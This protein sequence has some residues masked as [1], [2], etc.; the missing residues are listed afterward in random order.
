MARFSGAKPS[1]E[2]IIAKN[3]AR[4]NAVLATY[5]CVFLAIGLLV[6]VVRI[7]ANS[8]GGGLLS[9]ITFQTFPLV[10]VIMFGVA[11]ALIAVMLGNFKKIMLSGSEY[12]KIDPNKVLSRKEREIYGLLEDLVSASKTPFTPELYIMDAPYMN[13]F[14]SGWDEKNS[15]IALTSALV[16]NLEPDEL[17]AVIAHELS[18]IRHGDVRLT[19]AVGI[20]GNVMLL[21]ANYAIY[22]FG[23]NQKNSGANLARVILL[24]L[25]VVLPFLTMFLQMYL[26]RSREYMADSGAAFIMGDSKPMIRALQK[27]SEGYK[28]S[29]FSGVDVNPTRRAAYLFDFKE[30]FSTHP[31]IEN[32]IKSLL[33]NG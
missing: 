22:L 24:V 20:L 11:I 5:L 32:R 19:L 16:E 27:I 15:L 33:G 9:L 21:A 12:K 1:F 14:A 3:R 17:K 4:T 31:S 23:G 18:H 30:A 8:L 13:A 25:Q 10:A 6:D 28:R 7:N 29:D 2:A 26:S